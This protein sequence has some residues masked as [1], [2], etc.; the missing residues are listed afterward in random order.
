MPPAQKKKAAYTPPKDLNALLAA[1]QKKYGSSIVRNDTLKKV[2]FIPTG[3]TALDIAM[4]GGVP[5]GRVSE[6]LGKPGSGKTGTLISMLVQAQKMFPDRAV[7][8]VDIERTWT[9]EWAEAL[10]LDLKRLA[11]AKPKYAEEASDIARD[12][13][14]SGLI[15][16]IGI[17]SIGGMERQETLYEKSAEDNDMGKNAQV[18][19]R[20]AKQLATIGNDND[21]ATV[22]VN[23][24]RADLKN[25]GYDKASGP[26]ILSYATSCS[27]S[28]RGT[29][30]Q[31][32]IYTEKR[33]GEDITLSYKIATRVIRSKLIAAGRG[34]EYWFNKEPSERGP[35][36]IDEIPELVGLAQMKSIITPGNGSWWFLPNG[37]KANGQ[38]QL[39]AYVREHLDVQQTL[40][41]ALITSV[42]PDLIDQ[43]EVEFVTV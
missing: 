42:G 4:G 3:C 19:T 24:Y 18:I 23:Q 37:E 35:V 25:P 38:A 11:F 20:M 9:D 15:S 22:F 1:S 17:D 39:V 7:A 8:Y 21:V 16:A 33:N 26:M 29:G 30:G 43:P 14:R 41:D 27:V 36:G 32:N 28:F 2:Q 5:V 6:F 12:W 40:R 10:G 31:G 13:I 34:A